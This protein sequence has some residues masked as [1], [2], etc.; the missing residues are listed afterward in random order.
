MKSSLYSGNVYTNDTDPL[1][2]LCDVRVVDT[3]PE[4]VAENLRPFFR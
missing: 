4:V 2:R 3:L 1:K